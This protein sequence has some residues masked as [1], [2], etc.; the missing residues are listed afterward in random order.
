MIAA[1]VLLAIAGW[2]VYKPLQ[3]AED[4][5]NHQCAVI[6]GLKAALPPKPENVNVNGNATG[7]EDPGVI[8]V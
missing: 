5:A 6:R 1:L 2:M 8:S 3:A 4:F 7:L